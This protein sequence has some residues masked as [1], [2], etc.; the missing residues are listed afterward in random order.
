[1][2]KSGAEGVYVAAI[3]ACGI[4][5][6]VK[7]EDGAGRAAEVAIAALVARH[8]LLDESERE[9]LRPL[10]EA[11]VANVAGRLVGAIAPAPNW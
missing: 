6:A 11:P 10:I 1:M 8:A 3:F 4:G 7:I 5:V 2:I 9:A